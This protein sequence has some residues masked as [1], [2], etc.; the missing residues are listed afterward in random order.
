MEIEVEN[1]KN[2]IDDIKANMDNIKR[3]SEISLNGY[4]ENLIYYSGF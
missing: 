1:V 3:C 4:T 2:F